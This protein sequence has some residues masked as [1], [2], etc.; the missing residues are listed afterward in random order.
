MK[1]WIDGGVVEGRDARVPVTDHGFLYGDGIF[2]GIRVYEGT[3]FR[4]EEHI[5]RLYESARTIA[6]RI[7]MD[8]DQMIAATPESVVPSRSPA[9]CR[10]GRAPRRKERSCPR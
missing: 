8:R 7:P 3:V 4:L 6:L 10:C 5:D 1:V 2:E 9:R